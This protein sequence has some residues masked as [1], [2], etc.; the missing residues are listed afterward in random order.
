MHPELRDVPFVYCRGAWDEDVM[1]F[2]DKTLCKMLQKA[3]A[4]NDPD[5][6]EV[7]E[8]ALLCAIG[9]K[10]DWTDKKYLEPVLSYLRKNSV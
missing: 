6:C 2:P 3:V 5:T 8:K 10:C 7:W 9:Q 4:R 1:T